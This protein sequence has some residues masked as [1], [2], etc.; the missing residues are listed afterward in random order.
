MLASHSLISTVA[1]GIISRC[2]VIPIPVLLR[3]PPARLV[4]EVISTILSLHRYG[5]GL[6][7]IY[8]SIRDMIT[9]LVPVS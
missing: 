4:G 1:D 8:L 2:S 6:G 5:M 3:V 7:A 9:I